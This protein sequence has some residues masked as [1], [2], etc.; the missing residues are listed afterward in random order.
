MLPVFFI[1]HTEKAYAQKES[2]EAVNQQIWS[3]FTK[4]FE[5]QDYK[6]FESFHHRDFI[7][8]SGNGKSIKGK[9]KYIDS[10]KTRWEGSQLD[11]TISFRFLERINNGAVGSERGIYKL[12]IDPNTNKERAYYG[13]FHVVLKK[14]NEQWYILMD[15]DSDEGGTINDTNYL[16]AFAIDDLDKY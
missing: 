11:Q 10:Y 13:K 16:E 2:L 15:Y 3:N 1:L 12:V 5:T 6:L 8:I 4:A 9:S 7:R 14:E